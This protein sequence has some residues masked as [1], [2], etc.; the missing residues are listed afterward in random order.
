M[1]KAKQSAQEFVKSSCVVMEWQPKLWIMMCTQEA[2]N[3]NRSE[4]WKPVFSILCLSVLNTKILAGVQSLSSDEKILSI[5]KSIIKSIDVVG[6]AT[7]LAFSLSVLF[8][9]IPRSVEC[10]TLLLLCC[11]KIILKVQE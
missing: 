1:H 8:C 11:S 2:L 5:F 4:P 3:Q 9:E 7:Q 10:G 6:S